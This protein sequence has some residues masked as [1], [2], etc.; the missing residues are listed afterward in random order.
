MEME[1]EI[2]IF[3]VFTCSKSTAPSFYVSAVFLFCSFL[4][5]TS[6]KKPVA[7]FKIF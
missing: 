6:E 1:I 5:I 2:I 3:V 7:S 4:G